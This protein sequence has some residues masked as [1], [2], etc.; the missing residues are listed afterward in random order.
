MSS[1]WN[2]SKDVEDL[3]N[4]LVNSV[5]EDTGEVDE[6]IMSVL[7]VKEEEFSNKAI[8]VA[9]VYRR[10]DS[11]QALVDAEIKRLQGINEKIKNVRERLKKS[12]S[13]AC[14]RLGKTKI[15]GISASVS[16]RKSE[17]VVVDNEA[18]LPDELFNITITKKP[19]LTAIKQRFKNGE[20]VNGAKLV[21]CQNIQIK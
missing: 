5:D 20:E 2:L 18:D 7:A 13:E 14:L 17:R 10:F 3:Y 1:L 12:L 15:D 19:D 16:F 9:T 11:Q 8:A 4:E 6:N 21:V